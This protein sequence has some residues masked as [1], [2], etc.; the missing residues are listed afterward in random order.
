MGVEGLSQ[1][2][3]VVEGAEACSLQLHLDKLVALG[4]KEL[5]LGW[6]RVLQ[7]A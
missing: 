7:G 5:W 1:N 2:C 6:G 3:K 4:L